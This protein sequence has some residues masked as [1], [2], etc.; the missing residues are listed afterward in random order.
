VDLIVTA[1]GVSSFVVIRDNNKGI[2]MA[3]PLKSNLQ[4]ATTLLSLIQYK[5]NQ[6]YEIEKYF[7][8]ECYANGREHGYAIVGM[9]FIGFGSRKP[10]PQGLL[11]SRLRR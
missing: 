4:V 2:I 9:N 8:V 11:R 5:L 7:Y 10:L 1:I 6:D 3:I